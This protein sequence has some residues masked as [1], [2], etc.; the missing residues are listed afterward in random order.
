[1]VRGQGHVIHFEFWDPND[2]SGMAKARIVK[3]YT[4]VECI[5]S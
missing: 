1:M 2:I 4:Q 3:F 5:R